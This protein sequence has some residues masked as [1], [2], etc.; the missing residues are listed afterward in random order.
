VEERHCLLHYTV[1]ASGGEYVVRSRPC[2]SSGIRGCEADTRSFERRSV[3]IGVADIAGLLHFDSQP[4]GEF[5]QPCQF[6]LGAPDHLA[7]PEALSDTLDAWC[8]LATEHGR[9][10]S[11]PSC[12]SHS[13]KIMEVYRACF[14]TGWQK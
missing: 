8:V 12:C 11:K 4:V 2:G 13:V 10:N 3:A 9:G 7:D 1:P 6:V 14:V 5:T